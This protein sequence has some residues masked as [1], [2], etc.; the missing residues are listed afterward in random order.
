MVDVAQDVRKMVVAEV[1]APCAFLVAQPLDNAHPRF[2][3]DQVRESSSMR[4]NDSSGPMEQGLRV[5]QCG[6]WVIGEYCNFHIE[7]ICDIIDHPHNPVVIIEV[8]LPG[9]PDEDDGVLG[10]VG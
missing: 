7:A 3:E 2:T 5:G 4:R 6:Q 9:S 1:I 8:V 10:D